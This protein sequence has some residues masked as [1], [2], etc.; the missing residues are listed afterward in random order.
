MSVIQVEK[1]VKDY[2]SGKGV[3]GISFA[4][5]EGEVYGYLGPNGA[6]KSTTMRHL[7]GF[8]N[9]DSGKAMINGLDCWK[10]QVQIKE[11]IGYLPGEI[12]LPTDMTGLSYLKLIAKMRKMESFG[13]AEKLLD[14]F[15]INP[16]TSIKRMSKGMKQKIAIV[17]TFM[18]EPD[19]ILLDEPT[20]GLDPLMQ[21]RFIEL[22][23]AEKEKGKTILM[24]SHI[25]EEVSK[26]CDRV[27]ILKEGHLIRETDIDELKHADV[28]TY[29]IELN[30]EESFYKITELYRNRAEFSKEKKQMLITVSDED[31]NE[32]IC[33]LSKCDVKFI[34]EQK[35]SLEEYF[36]QYY[37][38]ASNV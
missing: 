31:I 29:K 23:K 20:S 4:L 35:H 14:M 38:G 6:G 5:E 32:L 36:M 30:T 24:S 2:G 11:S 34:S 22:V 25:F 10:N 8:S 15:E 9:P 17:A 27:G 21:E 13:V 3:F 12:A 1:L 37:G 16:D 26:V 28:K 19:V 7:M 18:H 33:A